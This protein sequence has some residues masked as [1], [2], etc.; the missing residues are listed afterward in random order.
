MLFVHERVI[1][2][3]VLAHP[4]STGVFFM[5]AE[6]NKARENPLV[7]YDLVTRRALIAVGESVAPSCVQRSVR[8]GSRFRP[9]STNSQER[10]HDPWSVQAARDEGERHPLPRLVSPNGCDAARRQSISSSLSRA[11]T[12]S[13]ARDRELCERMAYPRRFKS[14]LAH[15]SQDQRVQTTGPTLRAPPWPVI[16]R[17]LKW[18][19][20]SQRFRLSTASRNKLWSFRFLFQAHISRWRR[21]SEV[22]DLPETAAFDSQTAHLICHLSSAIIA[23]H[24]RNGAA[25]LLSE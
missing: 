18:Q 12:T 3:P 11:V 13:S 4:V 14:R 17:D 20:S 23:F 10:R 16:R 24:T 6:G 5:V 22:L 7:P 21:N 19:P 2:V 1:P 8:D 25:P 15:G 9:A